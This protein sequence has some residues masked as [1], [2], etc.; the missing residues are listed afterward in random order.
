MIKKA[1]LSFAG[2]S[3][4][5]AMDVIE[6]RDIAW[7]VPTWLEAPSAGYKT[8]ERIVRLDAFPHQVTPGSP[9]GDFL[10]TQPLPKGVF[11]DPAP[12]KEAHWLSF[13]M[14]PDIRVDTRAGKLH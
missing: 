3:I 10:L 4:I 14:S 11:F 7:L 1:A 5:Y 9:F 6:Y 2:E 8:P 13:E 12:L